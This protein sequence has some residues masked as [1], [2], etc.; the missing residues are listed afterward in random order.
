MLKEYKIIFS[1]ILLNASIGILEHEKLSEQPLY[2]D[3]KFSIRIKNQINDQDIRTIID[4]RCLHEII[5]NECKC[6]HI[7]LIETLI[8]RIMFRLTVKFPEI[9]H[10]YL[11]I[12]KPMA[13]LD[14]D[15]VSIELEH[16]H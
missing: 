12:S 4:Y 15:S 9:H 16:T 7:N 10:I 11:R 2:I 5:I 13:F 8:E 14:C 6:T 3:A 1:K